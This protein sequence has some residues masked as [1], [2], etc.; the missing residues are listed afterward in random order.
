MDLSTIP[1]DLVTPP[2]T[3]GEPT[4]G[5]RVRMGL[6]GYEATAVHHALY[7]PTDWLVIGSWPVI[8]E[9]AGNRWR[10]SPGTV[11]GSNLG[12][13]ISGGAGAIWLSLPYVDAENA[14]NATTWWGD[15]AATVDYCIRAVR[16]TCA[17][18]GGDPDRVVLAGFSR[19]SIACNFIGLHNDEISSLWRAFVYH[20]HYEGV[21]P[22]PYPGSDRQSARTRLRRLGNRQQFISHEASVEETRTYLNEAYPTGSF[23]F[24]ALPFDDH[25]DTWVIVSPVTVLLDTIRSVCRLPSHPT[26]TLWQ[27]SLKSSLAGRTTGRIVPVWTRK[28]SA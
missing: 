27:A 17:D 16:R 15:V 12:Y 1:P 18:F 8:V 23:A 26:Q 10:T 24:H 2:V 20:S 3:E 14:C 13:G 25:T 28:Q 6:L 5:R 4:P 9:Y 11:D 7:L 22:W 21:R 19:G